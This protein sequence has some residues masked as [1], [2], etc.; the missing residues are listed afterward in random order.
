[1]DGMAEEEAKGMN[2][3]RRGGGETVVGSGHTSLLWQI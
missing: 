3:N 1:M 2:K